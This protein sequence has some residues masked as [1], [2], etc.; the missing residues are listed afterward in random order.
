MTPQL[1]ANP[2]FHVEHVGSLLR[3]KELLD[4]RSQLQHQQCTADEL[5]VVEDAAVASVVKLQQEL[6]IRTITDGEMRR[7]TIVSTENV[8]RNLPRLIGLFSSTGCSMD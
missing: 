4:K 6:G 5:K 3:P 7:Y 8:Y 1:H 2:P